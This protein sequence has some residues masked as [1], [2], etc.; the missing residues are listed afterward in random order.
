MNYMTG[1][2]I[3]LGV[4]GGIAAYKSAELVRQL[5]LSGAVV[6]VVM[7]SAATEFI[8]PLTLQAL[9]GNPVHT[10][11]LDPAAEAA[12]GHIE[13]ARWADALLVAPATADFIARVAEGRANDLLA[14]VCLA[15]DAPIAIA[16]AMNQA[17]WKNSATGENLATLRAR[18]IRVLGPAEGL[19]ACGETG[20]GR[21][22]EP[23][24]LVVGLSGMFQTGVLAGRQ[25]LV[26][27]GPTR[28]A[29]DPVRYLS[30]HSSGRMGFAVA[31]AAAEAGAAVTLISGPVSLA[32]P[33]G[34]QRIDV[35]SAADMYAAV[36]Q[37]VTAADIYI[38]VAAVADY[39][40]ALVAP[41]KLKKESAESSLD[42]IRNPDILAAVAALPNA[43][44]TAGF[45]AET[46]AV[47]TNAQDK[48]RAKGVDMIAANKVGAGLAFD[49]EE[50]ALH[51][52]W[53]T[54][55]QMLPVTGKGKLAR[56]LLD[57]IAEQFQNSCHQ[58][59]VLRFNAK[60]SA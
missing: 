44:F 19:Q 60:D 27:A 48:R 11:L 31:T 9:S 15:C 30:N 56:Q 23:E 45:A 10:D 59:K 7:T 52:F 49:C 35:E 38:S 21:M 22:L 16:P 36:M 51:V 32:T 34:V 39:R 24:D 25:V 46:E 6:R 37:A 33:A 55:E 42:L 4:T 5:R 2:H 8:T 20:P 54:G 12:M 50:N 1:K 17:M 13:L 41:Q 40:P 47:E 26:T 3:L 57:L 58:G 28:E 53:E 29:I 43:P 14:A 18:N